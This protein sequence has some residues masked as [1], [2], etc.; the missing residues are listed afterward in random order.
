MAK[1]G[2]DV[3]KQLT[4][5]IDLFGSI[6]QQYVIANKFNFDYVSLTYFHLDMAIEFI[7]YVQIV[8]N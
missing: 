2:G 8:C 5:E 1:I 3:T 4:R 6:M 7:V